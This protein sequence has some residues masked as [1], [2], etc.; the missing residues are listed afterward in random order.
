MCKCK[1]NKQSYSSENCM[2]QIFKCFYEHSCLLPFSLK[3]DKYLTTESNLCKMNTPQELNLYVRIGWFVP[4]VSIGCLTWRPERV[5]KHLLGVCLCACMHEHVCKFVCTY[6]CVYVCA[7]LCLYE[8]TG[9]C[10]WL[11]MHVCVFVCVL[12]YMNV[13]AYWHVRACLCT[14]VRTRLCVC[15]CVR[16]QVHSFK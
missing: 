11:Y 14:S 9:F 1:Y 16:T 8:H 5:C 12:L 13:C 4:Q 10:V 3:T 7:C 15:L 6:I 2:F